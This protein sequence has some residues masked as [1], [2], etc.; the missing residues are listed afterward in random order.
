MA[1]LKCRG[2]KLVKL[3][4]VYDHKAGILIA[5]KKYK[6]KKRVKKPYLIR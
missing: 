3:V 1:I 4:Y 5:S 2:D 6:S